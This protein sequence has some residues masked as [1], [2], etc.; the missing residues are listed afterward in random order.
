MCYYITATLPASAD[1]KR[2]RAVGQKHSIAL[3]PMSNA[4]LHHQLPAG[5]C[6][7][8]TSSGH[9]A[10]GTVLGSRR[11]ERRRKE[12]EKDAVLR[13]IAK[14]R[15]EGWTEV[16]IRRWLDQHDKVETRNERVITEHTDTA[17]QKLF[18]GNNS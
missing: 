13:K 4:S 5:E 12:N 10:C 6:Q 3:H 7:F 15:K 8:L 17:R 16:K 9:C 14:L 11:Q 1:L 18:G 2:L